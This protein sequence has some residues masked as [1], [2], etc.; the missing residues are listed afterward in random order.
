MPVIFYKDLYSGIKRAI[1]EDKTSKKSWRNIIWK[2]WISIRIWCQVKL[3]DNVS[4]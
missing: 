2:W 1:K 3:L 4:L